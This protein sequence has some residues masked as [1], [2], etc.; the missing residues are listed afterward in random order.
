VNLDASCTA[1]QQA[2]IDAIM[3]GNDAGAQDMVWSPRTGEILLYSGADRI[4]G[5]I[6]TDNVGRCYVADAM[7]QY[8]QT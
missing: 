2:F 6:G 4:L 7:Y 5:V 3:N 8:C 1:F